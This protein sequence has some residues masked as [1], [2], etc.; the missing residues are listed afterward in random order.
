VKRA[1]GRPALVVL[2]AFCGSFVVYLVAFALPYNLFAYA[3]RSPL[4]LGEITERGRPHAA[5]FLL[6][7]AALFGLYVLA[8]RACRLQPRG[9]LVPLVFVCGLALGLVMTLTYPIGAGDVIDYVTH[10]EE[11]AFHGEN[12]L[13]VPPAEI[14]GAVFARYSAYR[15]V[16]PN[17]GPVWMWISALVVG[18]VGRSSLAFNLLG[19]KLVAVA[20][21]ALTSLLVYAVLRRR[22]PSFALAG[23]L[24]FAWNPLLIYEFAAN[25][26]NDAV[27]VA[28]AVLGIYFWEKDRPLPMLAAITFSFL[29]KVPMVLLVPFLLVSAAR[30]REPGRG[31]WIRLV[32][33]GAF[34][35]AL[36]AVL[37]FSLPNP[38]GAFFNLSDRSDLF[39]HSL[40]AIGVLTLRLL[41]IE[42][43]AAQTLVRSAALM[44]L[45][46]WFIVR[47]WRTWTTPAHT[48]RHIYDVVLFLL[49]F[50][51]PWFQAWY[52]TWIVALA[53]L[54]PRA[55]APAQAG[56]FSMT[57]LI[58]YVVFGFAWF[59][60]LSFAN[61][62]NSLGINLAAVATTYLVPWGYTAWLWLGPRRRRK[63]V[64]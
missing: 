54:Y 48:L 62:G 4:S 17:Y 64:T 14:P 33:G 41:G 47:L 45:W 39:T 25:G 11:L 8:Y 10:G 28:F 38:L 31:F 12:P 51:T 18:V 42:A 20:A 9:W 63:A 61:W 26:H 2:L 19:F 22:A 29:V 58:S 59:W 24:F 23:L 15:Y 37:Y 44:L 16:S 36:V 6:A 40:P 27:M 57:V 13:V 32:G 34:V 52:V 55:T 60:F 53:A 3:A 46:S 50:V 7:F 21:H 1:S 30:R 43:V 35:F 56:L 49:L 5:V